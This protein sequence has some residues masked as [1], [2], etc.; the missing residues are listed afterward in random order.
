MRNPIAVWAL[1]KVL[2][3]YSSE[4][5]MRA[6]HVSQRTLKRKHAPFGL[7]ECVLVRAQGDASGDELIR[8]PIKDTALCALLVCFD[9]YAVLE[10]NL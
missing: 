3:H 10:T 7:G 4:A 1:P 8:A 2:P 5:T 9:V 6:K